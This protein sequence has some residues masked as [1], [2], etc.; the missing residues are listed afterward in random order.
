MKWEYKTVVHSARVH[1]SLEDRLNQLGLEGWEL[2]SLTGE[3]KGRSTDEN[4]GHGW[5]DESE[6]FLVFKRMEIR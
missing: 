5:R 4:H 2:V 3:R 1:G 6:F